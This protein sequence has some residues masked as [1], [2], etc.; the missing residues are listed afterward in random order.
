MF[1]KCCATKQWDITCTMTDV[2]KQICCLT[3]SQ[4]KDFNVADTKSYTQIHMQI[5]FFNNTPNINLSIIR[6]WYL[7]QR[8]TLWIISKSKPTKGYP[9][10]ESPASPD[11][12]TWGRNRNSA[13]QFLMSP[14][15]SKTIICPGHI[16]DIQRYT[17]WENIV[18]K[19]SE[20]C[21]CLSIFNRSIS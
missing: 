9:W 8:K 5:E 11:V 3:C 2:L 16:Q 17:K 7:L 18:S 14:V 13:P 15:W 12:P 10:L 4:C 21:T 20:V 6:Q 1:L 19:N